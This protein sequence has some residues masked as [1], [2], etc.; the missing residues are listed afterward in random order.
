MDLPNVSA[1]EVA[2][3]ILDCRRELKALKRLLRAIRS[4][5]D[6][7]NARRHRRTNRVEK[8]GNTKSA[9]EH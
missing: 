1:D 5:G 7:E 8:R 4:A 3:Q 6:A 2:E 9:S